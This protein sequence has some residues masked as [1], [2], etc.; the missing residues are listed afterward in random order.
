[1]LL[2]P[3]ASLSDPVAGEKLP[4]GKVLWDKPLRLPLLPD[5]LWQACRTCDSRPALDA[6]GLGFSGGSG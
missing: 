3:P 5:L 2:P 4:S 1:M 6:A